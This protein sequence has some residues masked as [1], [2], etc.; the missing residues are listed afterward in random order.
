M[1]EVT[2]TE[3]VTLFELKLIR[4]AGEVTE[5]NSWFE[6]PPPGVGVFTVI[7]AVPAVAMSA[8]VIAAV[9]FVTLTNVV[10]RGLPFQ[11]TTELESK[12][13]PRTVRV[14]GEPAGAAAVGESELICGTGL[15]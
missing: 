8:A 9:T 13:A 2:A 15:F 4:E 12:F 11:F 14:K 1:F 3:F 6:V 7:V 5:K 10:V